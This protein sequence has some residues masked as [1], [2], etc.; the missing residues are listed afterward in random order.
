VDDDDVLDP[1]RQLVPVG[2][3]GIGAFQRLLVFDQLVA[4]HAFVGQ[5]GQAGA[6]QAAQVARR[7][8]AARG[9]AHAEG[10]AGVDDRNLAMAHARV[11]PAAVDDG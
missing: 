1:P 3:R 11:S 2:G 7:G 4:R 10:A 9:R 6:D 5:L 8:V